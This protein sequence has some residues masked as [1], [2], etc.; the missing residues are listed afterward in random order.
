MIQT[1][2]RCMTPNTPVLELT[3]LTEG[4]LRLIY[5]LIDVIHDR[6]YKT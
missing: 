2:N 3:L 6:M 4:P 1:G 5:P